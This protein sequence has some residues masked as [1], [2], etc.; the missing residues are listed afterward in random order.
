MTIA[1][2]L[3]AT[4]HASPAFSADNLKIYKN[5]KLDKV[6]LSEIGLS[7]SGVSASLSPFEADVTWN[8]SDVDTPELF[9]EQ[10]YTTTRISRKNVLLWYYQFDDSDDDDDD[11]DDNDEDDDDSFSRGRAFDVEYRILSRSGVENALSHKNDSSSIIKAYLTE[12]PIECERKNK[13][14]IR[15]LGRVDLDL[16]ISRAKKSGKYFGTIEVTIITI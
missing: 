2:F 11:D 10:I 1:F 6:T 15:C 7:K 12:K 3:M 16:D 5:R 14:K 8:S 13:K 4:S 9:L